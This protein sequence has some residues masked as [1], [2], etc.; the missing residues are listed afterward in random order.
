MYK[1][2]IYHKATEC[3]NTVYNLSHIDSFR[4]SMLI[5]RFS[6]PGRQFKAHKVILA[7]CSKHFQELFDTAPPS[8]AGACYVILEATTADNMQALLEFMYKGEV[9]V[10][11]DALSSFLKS[12]EN[13]QVRLSLHASKNL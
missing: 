12:G 1:D 6:F 4:I 3:Q 10:S 5:L 13:L 9:H 7:A 11:Q 2:Q 8:H